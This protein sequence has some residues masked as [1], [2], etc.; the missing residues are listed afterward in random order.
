MLSQIFSKDDYQV[1][2]SDKAYNDLVFEVFDNKTT[3]TGG[4]FLGNIDQDKKI[5]IS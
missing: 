1:V 4:I 5:G 2:F 3:E